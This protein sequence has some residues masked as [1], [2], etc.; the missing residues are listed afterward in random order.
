MVTDKENDPENCECKLC[1]TDEW[2]K[3]AVAFMEAK[4][5]GTDGRAHQSSG[6]QGT[7]KGQPG[8]K[9]V[10]NQGG[11]KGAGIKGQDITTRKDEGQN[12]LSTAIKK[13]PTRNLPKDQERAQVTS[14]RPVTSAAAP[15]APMT[16]TPN[17]MS[18]TPL[19]PAR[20]FQQALDAQINKFMFR[21]GELVWF[22]RG[23]A[24]GL[25]VIT[26]RQLY[27]DQRHQDCPQY[28]VQPLSHPYTHPPAMMISQEKQ[29]RPWLAWSAPDPTHAALANKGLR[30]QDVD[31]NGVI[32]GRYGA[33]DPEVDGSIF[34][35]KAIDECYT[36]FEPISDGSSNSSEV[37]Y[38][39][40]FCGGEKIWVG[41][42]IRLR[43]GAGKDLM[44]LR[45]VVERSTQRS[46]GSFSQDLY[47]IGDI[48]TYRT[49]TYSPKSQIPAN[50]FL[51]SRMQ[52][53]LNYRNRATIAHKSQISYW[54]ITQSQ[55]RLGLGEVKGRWYE[56]RTLLP[57][58]K[59]DIVF[60]QAMSKGEIDDVGTM[61]NGRGDA[62]H[63]ANSLGKRK[64]DRL[65][66]FGAALPVGTTIEGQ[67]VATP[68]VAFPMDPALTGSNIEMGIGDSMGQPGNDTDMSEFV[69]VNQMEE[70]DYSQSYLGRLGNGAQF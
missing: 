52:E 26:T 22:N 65:E 42:A 20:N 35:A 6:Y 25:S 27:K 70:T 13:E 44:I 51:P 58:L 3:N 68:Q 11:S 45:R 5:V 10:A 15:K 24:W 8:S 34:A 30:Y 40:V 57:I 19:A 37:Y 16:V 31:W 62:N 4:T 7:G 60:A 39:G 32:A 36:P 61:L 38:N 64:N 33:G 21:P 9:G 2:T 47:V 50:N 46:D 41:E 14:Q 67:V 29:L 55:A 59:G 63:S 69:D 54:K 18:P 56:S 53:D 43:S 28:S 12:S 66:T 48:Y 23:N 49:M 1:C 17:L